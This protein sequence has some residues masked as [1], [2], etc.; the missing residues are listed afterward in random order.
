MRHREQVGRSCRKKK[1]VRSLA[2]EELRGCYDARRSSPE[3]S[4]LSAEVCLCPLRKAIVRLRGLVV[5]FG[6]LAYIL[7]VHLVRRSRVRHRHIQ[8]VYVR[9]SFRRRTHGHSVEQSLNHARQ[10]GEHAR[11]AR[12]V[13]SACAL[14]SYKQTQTRLRRLTPASVRRVAGRSNELTEGRMDEPTDAWTDGE[15]Y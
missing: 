5:R 1:P 8:G 11:R 3:N 10:N 6:Q 15:T 14:D 13:R 12:S 4:Q 9:M 2:A 7:L